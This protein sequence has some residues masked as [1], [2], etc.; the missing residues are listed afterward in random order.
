MNIKLSKSSQ[1]ILFRNKYSGLLF[2][3][4]KKLQSY[5]DKT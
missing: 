2:E 3:K 5:V 4:T 1:H